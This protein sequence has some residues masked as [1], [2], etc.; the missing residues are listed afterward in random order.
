MCSTTA[1]L[2][3]SRFTPGSVERISAVNEMRSGGA[4]CAQAAPAMEPSA[5]ATAALNKWFFID[6]FSWGCAGAPLQAAASSSGS[7]VRL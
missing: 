1:S 6:T 7:A 5:S 3:L 4:D 2:L